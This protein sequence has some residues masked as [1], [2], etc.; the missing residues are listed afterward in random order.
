MPEAFKFPI[1]ELAE[2]IKRNHQDEAKT[3]K[4]G[5]SPK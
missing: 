1:I 5:D 4:K 2:M 3:V